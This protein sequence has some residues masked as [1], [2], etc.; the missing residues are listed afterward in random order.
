MS[1]KTTV[2][3]DAGPDRS[4]VKNPSPNS[5]LALPFEWRS[6]HQEGE[7]TTLRPRTP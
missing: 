5:G 2:R 4:A 3:R 6:P 1:D 7:E